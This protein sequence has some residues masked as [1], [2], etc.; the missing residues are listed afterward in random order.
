VGP[1]VRFPTVQ[2]GVA[3]SAEVEGGWKGKITRMLQR[4]VGLQ[5]GYKF[6]SRANFFNVTRIDL[7]LKKTDPKPTQSTQKNRQ[8]QPHTQSP[9]RVIVAELN[10]KYNQLR[11]C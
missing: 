11:L 2:I 8:R 3:G 7:I 5:N 1:A 9:S 6:N 4:R 10:K